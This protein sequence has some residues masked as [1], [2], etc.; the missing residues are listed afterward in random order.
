MLQIVTV[1]VIIIIII[2][3]TIF[4]RTYRPEVR[5]I[6]TLTLNPLTWKI[7]WAPINVSRWQMGFN[8]AL[9]GF[10]LLDVY[11]STYFVEMLVLSS[12]KLCTFSLFFILD[13]WT[14]Q[15]VYKVHCDRNVLCQWWVNQIQVS[16]IGGVILWRENR[17]TWRR[18]CPSSSLYTTNLM[19]PG[20]ELNW[21][22]CTKSLTTNC[23]SLAQRY[24]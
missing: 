14:V 6:W 7:W 10:I 12:T 17:S 22:I 20:L 5:I 4:M 18:T 21:V 11:S 24:Y 16:N 23:L 19:W 8:S 15:P 9:K 1:V 3:T 2:T 13:S